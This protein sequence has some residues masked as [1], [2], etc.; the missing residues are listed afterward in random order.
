MLYMPLAIVYSRRFFFENNYSLFF[1]NYKVNKLY[2]IDTNY[3]RKKFA[4]NL[5]NDYKVKMGG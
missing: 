2:C 4:N 1:T 3:L 5:F